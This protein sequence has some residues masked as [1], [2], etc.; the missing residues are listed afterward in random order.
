VRLLGSGN[1]GVRS[2]AAG[3]LGWLAG[4]NS[5]IQA[6]IATQPNVVPTLVRLLGSGS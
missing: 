5:D 6:A 3:V 2:N 4:C 1:E